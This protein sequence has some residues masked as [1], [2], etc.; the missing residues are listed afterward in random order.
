MKI[1]AIK[2]FICGR[3]EASRGEVIDVSEKD[4]KRLAEKG[5]AELLEEK[6]QSSEQETEQKSRKAISGRKTR[7]GKQES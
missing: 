5:I 6:D 7:S 2:N 4:A 3:L 1:K